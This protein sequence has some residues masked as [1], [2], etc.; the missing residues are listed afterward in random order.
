MGHRKWANDH[1]Q[2]R[3]YLNIIKTFGDLR[4]DYPPPQKRLIIL[5]KTI[6][7]ILK[8]GGALDFILKCDMYMYTFDIMC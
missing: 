1:V 4:Q 2:M 3:K 8:Q 5:N 7:S 6:H